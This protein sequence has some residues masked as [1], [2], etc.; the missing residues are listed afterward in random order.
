MMHQVKPRWF[1]C[2][3]IGAILLSVSK[4][5]H[6]SYINI[7]PLFSKTT[8][9]EEILTCSKLIDEAL[10]NDGYFVTSYENITKILNP[11]IFDAANDLFSQNASTKLN[12]SINNLQSHGRGY[13][14]FGSEAGVSTYYE[15][16]EGF[17][18]GCSSV[19]NLT[20]PLKYE[21]P[22]QQQNIWPGSLRNE[23]I[24]NLEEL[25][26]LKSILAN[27]ILQA[28]KIVL[29]TENRNLKV[30]NNQKE[31]NHLNPDFLDQELPGGDRISLMRIFH[32]F[33]NTSCK[34][35]T[36]NTNIPDFTKISD[37]TLIGSSPH[38][39]WGLLTVITYNGVEG[40]E[41]FNK[42]SLEWE[43]LE[44]IKN[45]IVI[46]GGDYLQLLSH[47][48]YHSPVHRVVLPSQKSSAI[49]S[50]NKNNNDNNNDNDDSQ[51]TTTTA[52]ST[53]TPPMSTL[54]ENYYNKK[55][56][57]QNRLSF[58]FFFYP[59]YDS[60]L[61]HRVTSTKR[62]CQQDQTTQQHSSDIPTTIPT[63]ND[64]PI[65]DKNSNS[66]S[67]EYNTLLNTEDS[68]L[69]TNNHGNII[70]KEQNVNKQ[71]CTIQQQSK[72]E[73]KVLFGDYILEKWQGVYR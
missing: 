37:K 20:H 52:T 50:N 64:N 43:K 14:P 1:N 26:K 16:K 42:Y 28:L 45:G 11:Q 6:S 41:F 21:H 48:R 47:N 2:C 53:S 15:L 55:D 33:T 70:N 62:K 44:Y 51:T 38:T 30:N 12:Y 34:Q 23:T 68:N 13:L 60:I 73:E 24:S 29:V 65:L 32:Y 35:C 49:T 40:L 54:N 66:N 56:S 67:F 69:S 19:S 4:T 9:F 7:A 31:N 57:L 5:M 10:Q 8:S 18:Y 27:T 59:K 3:C 36:T 72:D 46:N 71:E 25:F 39:D 17:S 63:T 22:L 58:V 61:P